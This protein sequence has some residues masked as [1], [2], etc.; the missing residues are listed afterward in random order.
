MGVVRMVVPQNVQEIRD[1]PISVQV[2]CR[3]TTAFPAVCADFEMG[4]DFSQPHVVQRSRIDPSETQVGST[5]S[6]TV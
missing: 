2:C 6:T 4:V 3:T 5:R 1:S